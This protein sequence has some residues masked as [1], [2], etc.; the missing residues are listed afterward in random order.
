MPFHTPGNMVALSAVLL[1][2]MGFAAMVLRMRMS[3]DGS[4]TTARRD[5]GSTFGMALQGLAMGLAWM[6]GVHFGGPVSRAD[7]ISAGVP[8]TLAALSV[9]LFAWSTATMGANWSL[10]ARTRAGH[11]LV[12]DGPFAIVRNPIYVALFGMVCALS[13]ALG[14]A[15]NLIAAVPVYVI[16]TLWRVRIEERLLRETFGQAYEDY[17][18]RVKCFIPMVW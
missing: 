11:T 14:H 1:C 9:G 13:M 16:G 3:A 6:G 12:Q 2:G 4:T 5:V 7:W 17:S 8:A 10:A 18:R 15:I